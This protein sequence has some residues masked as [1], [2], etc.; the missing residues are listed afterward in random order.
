[1]LDASGRRIAPLRKGGWHSSEPDIAAVSPTGEVQAKAFGRTLISI[2]GPGG[3]GD[4][5]EVFVGGDL[6]VTSN[7]GG[8]R[9]GIYQ[10]SLA[11]PDSLFPLLAD[12]AVYLGAVY[13]VDRTRIAFATAR[14][15]SVALWVTEADASGTPQLVLRM[16]GST[17]SLV[18]MPDGRRLVFAI[19]TKD[20]ST[21]GLLDLSAVSWD[22]LGRVEGDPTPDVARDGT[23]AYASGDKNRSDIYLIKAG[24]KVA[25][26]L[27]NTPV[28]KWSPRW[29][30][31]GDLLFLVEDTREQERFRIIRY[32]PKTGNQAPL[33]RSKLPI[34]SLTVAPDGGSIAYLARE[35]KKKPFSVL[36][37]SL[38]PGGP[39]RRLGLRSGE[40]VSAL[41]F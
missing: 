33:I 15:K 21:L 20:R 7:R 14:E 17:A 13:S 4:T 31:D 16:P 36:I 38:D 9:P 25:S 12:S 35:A 1:M 29:L 10:V 2:V 23:I 27:T 22:T 8:K 41:S 40:T 18:W 39:V 3:R 34:L 37:R 32:N 30:P 26:R 5:T 28:R 24:G 6:L 11:Q 19:G